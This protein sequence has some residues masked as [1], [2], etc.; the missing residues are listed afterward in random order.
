MT[1]TALVRQDTGEII[2]APD[3]V[4]LGVVRGSN[5]K[6]LVAAATE[7][8]NALASVIESKKL[9]SNIQ[10]K[11]FV[12]C[13]GW[14]TLAAI[15][16]VLPR[17]RSVVEAPEGVFIATVD[18]V[19]LSDGAVISSASAECGSDDEVDKYGKPLW[20]ARP[21]YARRSMAITR[22]TAKVCRIAFSWVM[23]LAGFEVTPAEEIP[24][25]EDGSPPEVRPTLTAIP[26]GKDK[27]KKLVDCADQHLAEVKAWC[28]EKGKFA[29]LV[30]AI[31]LELEGR[32]AAAEA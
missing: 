21:R 9:Y 17:E 27:G 16:G 23:A 7:A 8:A 31:D 2:E 22:A 30:E 14:T 29:D 11:R 19:R 18:L 15:M 6:A 24:D 28:V 32:R 3:T 20:S 5:P 25:K 12:R 1:K 4:E 13:E 10:G 26:F